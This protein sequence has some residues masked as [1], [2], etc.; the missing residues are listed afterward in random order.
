MFSCSCKWEQ[1]GTDWERL[2]TAPSEPP[3]EE[4]D[5][6]AA[7]PRLDTPFLRAAGMSKKNGGRK[8]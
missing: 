1:L 8:P 5:T 3:S 7:K 6:T 2:G 4:R